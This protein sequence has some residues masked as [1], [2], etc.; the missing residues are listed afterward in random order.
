LLD[1]SAIESGVMRL[2]P[3]WCDLRL[4]VEA[5]VDCLPGAESAR[6]AVGC[7]ASLPPIWA[8]PDRLEQLFVNLLSTAFRHNPS[9][10]TVTVSAHELRDGA[11][12]SPQVEVIVADDG[13]GFP[14]ER[15][16]APFEAPQRHRS[17]SSGAGLVLSIAGG[18]VAAHEGRIELV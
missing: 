6:V 18:I 2:Q 17:R 14:P 4:V 13:R 5:A 1:F 12:P 16:R 15:A 3:D 8:D 7:E 9:E 10:T 11:L